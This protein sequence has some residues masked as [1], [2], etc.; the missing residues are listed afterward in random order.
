MKATF[1]VSSKLEIEL[2]AKT[3]KEMFEHLAIW[4]EIFGIEKC[5]KCG[6]PNLKFVV[7]SA[8]KDDKT[9][10]YP[11]IHCKD[12]Y[13]RLGF[14]THDNDKGTLFPK[15]KDA[16]GNY[17]SDNGWQRWDKEQKKMV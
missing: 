10:N 11:E 3:Q 17:L 16:D 6:K 15:R 5:G 13:A 1:K 9:Y 4:E 12:C 7:R 8:K 14:G 2:E